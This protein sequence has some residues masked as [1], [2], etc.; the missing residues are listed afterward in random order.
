MDQ[1]IKK[2]TES[3]SSKKIEIED[4]ELYFSDPAYRTI[5]FSKENFHH[6]RKEASKIKVAFIDG[7]N[8]EIISTPSHTV[9]FIRIHHTI[10]NNFTKIKSITTEF[11]SEVFLE[12]KNN[13]M[14]FRT[15]IH[16]MK[17]SFGLPSEKDLV[18]SIEDETLKDGIFNTGI[19][20]IAGIIR[21]FS[22][23]SCACEIIRTD[24]DKGDMIVLDGTLQQSVTNEDVYLNKL[25]ELGN[26]NHVLI[27]GLAKTTTLVTK[28]GNPVSA[29]L[30]KLSEERDDIWYYHPSVAINKK[31][32]PADIYFVRLHKDSGFIFRFE[33]YKKQNMINVEKVIGN[34]ALMS[35]DPVFLGY[36]YGLI[37]ADSFARVSDEEA[38]FLNLRFRMI[39]KEVQKQEKTNSAHAVLDNIKF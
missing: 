23:L 38:K 4:D 34:L 24:L 21:R 7:G 2:I 26:E 30:E 20:K 33:I 36:P 6:A 10:F 22:E 3:F 25:L 17:N 27:T 37:D 31:S 35:Q 19:K 5:P 11:F 32:H 28:K 12:Q 15:K 39:S 9:N 13:K 14:H 16:P 29:V 1:I 18:F 8:S